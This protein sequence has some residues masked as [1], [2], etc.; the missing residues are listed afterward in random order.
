MLDDA[1]Y[2]LLW[3]LAIDTK[4]PPEFFLAVMASESGL[5][6]SVPN[7]AGADYYGINQIAGSYLKA[8]GITPATYLSW[9][10]S[11]QLSQIVV[12]YF[13]GQLAWWGK[14]IRS[15]GVL[16]SL[17]LCQP[18]MS[19]SDDPARVLAP[20]TGSPCGA[21][22]YAAN[23][24]LDFDSSGDITIG[25]LDASLAARVIGK[26]PYQAAY[27]RLYSAVPAGWNEAWRPAPVDIQTIG[28]RKFWPWGLGAAAI[29][30]G[31]ALW[32]KKRRRAI[33]RAF[34]R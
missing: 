1:S 14:P 22:A 12:P 31:W 13:K 11:Q 28:G 20:V 10:A 21:A 4:T 9:P 29:V 33:V 30:A 7:L 16:H 19:K 6:P 26:Q 8:R 15:P 3:K 25:D 32:S 2:P 23:K 17:A 34:S 5:R 24:G 27:D 18:D